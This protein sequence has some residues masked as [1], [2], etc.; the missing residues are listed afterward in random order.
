[1]DNGG[2]TISPFGPGFTSPSRVSGKLQGQGGYRQ[3]APLGLPR[4][5]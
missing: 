4:H 1:M 2:A 3:R 5:P